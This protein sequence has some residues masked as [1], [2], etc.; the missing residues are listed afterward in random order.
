[1]NEC[2]NDLLAAANQIILGKLWFPQGM[3]RYRK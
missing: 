2:L 1:M 3:A